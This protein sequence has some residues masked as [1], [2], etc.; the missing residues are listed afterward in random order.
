MKA[1]CVD[2]SPPF[3]LL[4]TQRGF[5]WCA[6]FTVGRHSGNWSSQLSPILTIV[7][8]SIF[9]A[10]LLIEENTHPCARNFGPSS[11]LPRS[12]ARFLLLNTLDVALHVCL[13]IILILWELDWISWLP[14]ICG[15]IPSFVRFRIAT[16]IHT[17]IHRYPDVTKHALSFNLAGIIHVLEA[18]PARSLVLSQFES[19]G[20]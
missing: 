4:S 13:G 7:C 9:I 19:H 20:R 18:D 11:L 17:Y 6:S 3:V 5:S 14:Q 1:T 8:W 12:S 15:A 2:K 16:V 10:T